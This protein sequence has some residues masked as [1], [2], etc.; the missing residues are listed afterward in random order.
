MARPK[1][2]ASDDPSAADQSHEEEHNGDDQQNPDEIPQGVTADHPEQPQDDQND[3]DGLEHVSTLP[4]VHSP[5][6]DR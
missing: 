6:C 5:G 2:G 3:R 4:E 1:T